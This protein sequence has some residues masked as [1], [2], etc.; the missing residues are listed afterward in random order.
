MKKIIIALTLITVI[1]CQKEEV[2]PTK[3]ISAIANNCSCGLI[4]SDDVEDYSI[5]IKN[6]CSGN[7]KKFILEPDKWMNAH[8]GNNYCMVSAGTW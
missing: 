6:Q 7:N 2:T 1:S 5:V 8:P 4:V 3:P